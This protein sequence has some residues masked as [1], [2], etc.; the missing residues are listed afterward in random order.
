MVM[1]QATVIEILDAASFRLRTDAIIILDGVTP[2]TKGS[3]AEKKAKE[4]LAELVLKKKISYE[5]TQFDEF[6][7]TKAKVQIDGI[8]VN[9]SMVDY[10][11][12]L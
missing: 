5:T 1:K 8:D 4:K 3:D 10:L 12:S 9:K 11:K 7:R 2:P 6:G